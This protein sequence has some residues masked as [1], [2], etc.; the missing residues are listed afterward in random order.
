[1]NEGIPI[2][3]AEPSSDASQAFKSLATH[4]RVEVH[5]EAAAASGRGFRLFG[6]RS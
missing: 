5:G 6:R 3:L 4:F 2:I 1:V